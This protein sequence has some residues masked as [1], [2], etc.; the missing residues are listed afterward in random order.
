M[1][2]LSKPATNAR[3]SEVLAYPLPVIYTNKHIFIGYDLHRLTW[4][5]AQIRT[6]HH[7]LTTAA[8]WP[9]ALPRGGAGQLAPPPPHLRSDTLRDQC[10]S[11]EIFMS[12][13]IYRSY[14]GRSFLWSYPYQKEKRRCRSC[15]RSYFDRPSV[16]LRGH[17][18][19]FSPAWALPN[20]TSFFFNCEFEPLPKTVYEIR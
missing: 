11:K 20:M 2:R 10:R 14:G 16:K 8:L 19:S 5:G 1:E 18:G 9:V 4:N 15:S 12:G 13:K 17:L 7:W 6:L 3:T